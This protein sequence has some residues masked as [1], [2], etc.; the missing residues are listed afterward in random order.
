MWAEWDDGLN[1]YRLLNSMESCF[2]PTRPSDSYHASNQEICDKLRLLMIR[3]TKSQRISGEAA[4]SLPDSDV[5]T[6]W[7]TMS[8]EEKVL[9]ALH[10]CAD[11]VPR[12][13]DAHRAAALS[14]KDLD[15]GLSKRRYA[16][17]SIYH[18]RAVT[19]AT[20]EKLATLT[21]PAPGR[22]RA[23]GARH[24]QWLQAEL[25]GS[26][27][28]LTQPVSVERRAERCTKYKA[29]LA[30]LTALHLSNPDA[31]VVLFTHH[32]STLDDVCR[33]L[34]MKMP[35]YTVF[36]VSRTSTPQ[37]RHQ[38]LRRFQAGGAGAGASTAAIARAPSR[39]SCR[40][41]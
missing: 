9:Y 30:D 14:L 18:E 39:T 2:H 33:M 35:Q 1:L 36:K 21:N 13:A 19:G 37:S 15:M 10:G 8:H 11:G 6:V 5:D 16:L 22:L 3:H 24:F 12:W 40:A 26:S 25:A 17:A 7:L 41:R 28:Y 32:N 29:V 27:S 31:S 4:L 38:A 34:S 20:S 23:E